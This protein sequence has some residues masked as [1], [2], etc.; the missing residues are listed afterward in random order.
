MGSNNVELADGGLFLFAVLVKPLPVGG[1]R[2]DGAVLGLAAVRLRGPTVG[3]VPVFVCDVHAGLVYPNTLLHH[4]VG[5]DP[6][7]LAGPDALADVVSE[8]A[9][10]IAGRWRAEDT[11][12]VVAVLTGRVVAFSHMVHQKALSVDLYAFQAD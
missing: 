3:R 5:T 9:I 8:L 2:H 10:L 11:A 7:L 4:V 1:P 6:D 12:K